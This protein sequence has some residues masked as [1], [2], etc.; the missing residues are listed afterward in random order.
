MMRYRSL[1]AGVALLA[2]LCGPADAAPKI[3]LVQETTVILKVRP[4]T[5]APG[6]EPAGGAFSMELDGDDGVELAFEL[7]WP[8]G[9]STSSLVLRA[10]EAVP[11]G[12]MA[13][14]VELQSELTL[15]GGRVVRSRKQF[16]FDSGAT[17]LFEL[18]NEGG[19]PLIVAIEAETSTATVVAEK[20]TV[21][22]PVLFRLEIQRLEGDRAIPLESN[23]LHTFIGQAVTYSFRL[24]GDP[25][26][27]SALVTLEPSR[28]LGEIAEINL[29]VSGTLPGNE[30]PVV[31]GKRE[32]WLASRGAATS[33]SF[34][35]G[36]PAAGYRF[37][38]TARF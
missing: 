20:P 23:L 26:S 9:G 13:H 21:G 14:A 1:T 10:A 22:R 2:A 34:T 17:T 30:G 6:S 7:L 33:L 8:E 12:D 18:S 19:R 24:G 29:E 27:D 11:R 31:L 16:E 5:A 36:E 38:V 28:L 3:D 4:L 32:R 35:A 37:V 15:P 25:E